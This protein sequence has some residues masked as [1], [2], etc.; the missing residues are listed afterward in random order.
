MVSLPESGYI[1]KRLLILLLAAIILI[2][3]CVELKTVEKGDVISVDY[4]ESLQDG[5]VLYTT[6]QSVAKENGIYSPGEEYTPF[7]FTVGKGDTI[8][9]FSRGVIGMKIGENKVFT[10]P[11]ENGFG[12]SKPELIRVYPIIEVV[13]AKIPRAIDISYDQFAA[14]FGQNHTAGDIVVHPGMGVNMTIRNISSRVSLYYNFKVGDQIPSSGPWN[15][16]VVKMDERNI[17]VKYSVKKNETIQFPNVPWNTTVVEVNE[18]NITLKNNAIPD[19]EI[20]SAF[21]QPVRVKFNE[22]SIIM[23]QNHKLAGKNLTFNV[24]IISIEKGAQ[25]SHGY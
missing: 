15:M 22:S 14:T 20:E 8:S 23:D 4:T 19:T 12:M 18:D 17:T 5:T 9:G 3:G 21:G 7:Q 13:P 16:T 11:P 2:S 25:E 1:M 10:V 24:T 6:I